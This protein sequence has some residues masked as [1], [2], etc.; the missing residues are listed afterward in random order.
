MPKNREIAI[1]L[2]GSNPVQCSAVIP[3]DAKS[4]IIYIS[5]P[6]HQN[7]TCHVLPIKTK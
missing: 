5:A 2:V 3:E 6:S 7:V 1:K 4:A